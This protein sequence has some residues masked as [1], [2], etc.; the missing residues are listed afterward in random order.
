[1]SAKEVLLSVI[2]PTYYRPAL[3]KRAL[4]SLLRPDGTPPEGVEILVGRQDDDFTT[5]EEFAGVRYLAIPE[6]ITLARKSNVLASYACGRWLVP[7][8]DDMVV[9]VPDWSERVI[10]AAESTKALVH[11]SLEGGGDFAYLPVVSREMINV[12]GWFCAPWFPYWFTDTWWDEI[13]TMTWGRRAVD[14]GLHQPSGA[15]SSGQPDLLFWVHVF[16]RLRSQRVETAAR[17]MGH[18]PSWD[19]IA[20]CEQRVAHLYSPDFISAWGS[21]LSM[22]QR[23]QEAVAQAKLAC[24][25]VR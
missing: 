14:V 25:I 10:Q 1:M 22:D 21:P 7:F 12:D 4:L 19:T 8:A 23:Y 2:L 3:L 6:Q 13:A 24:G 18:A 17:L 16:N 5:P 9:S 11:L 15:K 20:L